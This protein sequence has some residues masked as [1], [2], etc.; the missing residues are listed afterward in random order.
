MK[1]IF[2]S[3]VLCLFAFSGMGQDVD[4]SGTWKLNNEKSVLFEQFSLAPSQLIVTQTADTIVVEKHG[5][6]QGT[7]YVSKD[8]YSLDGKECVNPGM[9]GSKKT[10][11]AVWSEDKKVL[12]ITGKMP[13]QDQ[14][15]ATITEVFQMADV[16]LKVELSASSQ[17]GSM[18]ETYLLD[19][20]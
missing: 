8:K 3:L 11:T 12:T 7:E 4:F 9:M 20:Q 16:N 5:N 13:T 1:K 2:Y 6:F 14:G 10:S 15:E 17:M 18:A 19:K